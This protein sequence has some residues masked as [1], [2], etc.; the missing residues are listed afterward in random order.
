MHALVCMRTCR[1]G[2]M[3]ERNTKTNNNNINHQKWTHSEWIRFR[4]ASS[5]SSRSQKT[6]KS[7][8]DETTPKQRDRL[9]RLPNTCRPH[10]FMFSFI[11]CFFPQPSSALVSLAQT[12]YWP[13]SRPISIFICTIAHVTISVVT[14]VWLNVIFDLSASRQSAPAWIVWKKRIFVR[15]LRCR[16]PSLQCAK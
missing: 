3:V 1:R 12:H 11:L 13:F 6:W 15:A 8:M 16:T 9:R 10:Y 14:S 5:W 7:W 2:K 4:W